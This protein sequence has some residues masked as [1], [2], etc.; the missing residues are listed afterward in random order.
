M[1]R[2][3]EILHS[4]SSDSRQAVLKAGGR[5]ISL[6][7]IYTVESALHRVDFYMKDYGE[8]WDGSGGSAGSGQVI[9]VSK[10]FCKFTMEQYIAFLKHRP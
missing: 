7:Y 10:Q 8:K 9:T 2:V 5:H 4:I 3:V 6:A 1:K